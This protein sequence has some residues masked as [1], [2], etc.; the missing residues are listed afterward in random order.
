M[1]KQQKIKVPSTEMTVRALRRG[2][3]NLIDSL[4]FEL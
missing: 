3:Y 2:D 4:S 1:T